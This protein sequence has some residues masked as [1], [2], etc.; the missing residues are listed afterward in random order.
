GLTTAVLDVFAIGAAGVLSTLAAAKE[1][2]RLVRRKR[3]AL[4]DWVE[5]LIRLVQWEPQGE[6]G[7]DVE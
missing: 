4:D 7:V 2:Q 5:E 1:A 3:Q 6:S